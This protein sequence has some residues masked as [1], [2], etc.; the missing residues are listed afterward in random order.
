MPGDRPG[1]IPFG[2]QVT[3]KKVACMKSISGK[4]FPEG[5][6]RLQNP[7]IINQ[8]FKKDCAKIY[9]NLTGKFY[10]Y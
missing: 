3:V 2:Q 10:H 5:M 6:P 8:N 4:I 1:K 7:P 9:S